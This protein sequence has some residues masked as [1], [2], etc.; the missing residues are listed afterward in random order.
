MKTKLF[1]LPLARI[2][3][4]GLIACA[5][6]AARAEVEDK[7]AKS[8]TVSPGGQLVVAVD[9]GSIEIKTADADS[10]NL[11]V[12]RKAGGS[13]GKAEKTLKDHVVTATQDGNKIE[14]Q[15]EYKGEKSF[16]LLRRGPDLQVSVVLTIPRRFDVDLKTA[17]GH[18]HVAD[19]TG[20]VKAHTSGGNLNFEKID[21]PVS[22]H[23]SGGHIALA[24]SKGQVELKTSGGNLKLSRLEGDVIATTSGGHITADQL[25]GKS[26]VKTSGGN[27]EVKGIKGSIEA[28]T[29][30]GHVA[31]GLLERPAGECIL[32][33]SGGNINITLAED[34]SVDIDAHTSGGRISSALPVV[35]TIQGE[36]KRNELRGKIN[37][38]GPL[39]KAH[40][41]GGNVRLEKS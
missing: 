9:R 10:V 24:D 12:T 25:S 5:S 37:G 19:L 38:G 14:V 21:G 18:I 16:G 17:G 11:E 13:E 36:Q 2:V 35:A 20:K 4:T 15:A 31:A 23:T 30:G 29:S 32:S 22:A 7:I 33:T 6:A 3:L 39:I 41:S 28:R 1:H 27:I 34:V 8:F 40:T 26:V